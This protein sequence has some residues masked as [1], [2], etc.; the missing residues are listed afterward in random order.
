MIEYGLLASQSS[1][2]FY[3]IVSQLKESFY[4]NPYIMIAMGVCAVVFYFV[5]WK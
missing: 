2:M 3:G 1:E 4:Q 5:V